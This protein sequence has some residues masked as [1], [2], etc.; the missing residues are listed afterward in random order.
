MYLG[1][2]KYSDINSF[3]FMRYSNLF[4]VLLKHKEEYQKYGA[5][6]DTEN[7]QELIHNRMIFLIE[8]IELHFPFVPEIDFIT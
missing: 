4:F 6:N 8:S 1:C 7:K 5:S 2:V 3:E